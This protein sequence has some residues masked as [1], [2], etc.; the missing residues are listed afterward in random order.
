M[1]YDLWEEKKLIRLEREAVLRS[2]N[3]FKRIQWIGTGKYKG[4]GTQDCFY[5][6]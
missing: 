3:T 5:I 2:G 4:N 1:D 6:E